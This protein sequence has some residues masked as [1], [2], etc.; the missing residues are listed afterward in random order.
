MVVT[1][2]LSNLNISDVERSLSQSGRQSPVT[3]QEVPVRVIVVKS[4]TWVL[5]L[6]RALSLVAK[7][8]NLIVEPLRRIL[9]G[10]IATEEEGSSRSKEGFKIYREDS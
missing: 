5:L 9:K 6:Y 4:V 1:Y 10:S 7:A 3:L 8:L 2:W